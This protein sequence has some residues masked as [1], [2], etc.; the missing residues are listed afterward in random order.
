MERKQI[1]ISLPGLI[2]I[3]LKIVAIIA[4]GKYIGWW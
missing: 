4:L 3:L 2:D 1:S